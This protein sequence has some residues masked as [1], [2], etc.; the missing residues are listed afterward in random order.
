MGQGS[1]VN[2]SMC[3]THVQ[4]TLMRILKIVKNIPTVITVHHLEKGKK[5]SVTV[6]VTWSANLVTFIYFYISIGMD[7]EKEQNLVRQFI[8]QA[9]HSVIRR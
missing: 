3:S 5:E 7:K 8:P 6:C 2:L 1:P 9:Q 4:H